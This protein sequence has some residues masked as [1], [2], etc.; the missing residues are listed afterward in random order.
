MS[1]LVYI[2]TGLKKQ[3]LLAKDKVNENECAFKFYITWLE[4]ISIIQKITSVFQ[5]FQLL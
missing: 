5:V 4:T 2:I 3:R 1:G